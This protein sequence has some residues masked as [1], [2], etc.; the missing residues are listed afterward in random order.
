MNK[1]INHKFNFIIILILIYIFFNEIRFEELYD[2]DFLNSI[3]SMKSGEISI[4]INMRN[5]TEDK[6]II[7]SKI[8]DQLNS[9]RKFI[10]IK[11]EETF[12]DD[13]INYLIKNSSIKVVQS[14]FPDS[15]FLPL[16][17]S[18]VIIIQNIFYSL[19]KKA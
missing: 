12:L 10:F 18:M 9:T 6:F 15:I 5:L 8:M 11:T 4:I 3:N 17:I 13:N 14:N 19:T 1:H 16:V 7:F 2:Y